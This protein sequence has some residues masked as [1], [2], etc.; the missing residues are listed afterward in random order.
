MKSRWL[1]R[2]DQLLLAAALLATLAF[3]IWLSAP[4]SGAV[5][6]A[7]PS[8]T[9]VRPATSVL[10]ESTT[11][12]PPSTTPVP[13][14]HTK[15]PHTTQNWTPSPTTPEHSHSTTLPTSFEERTT[16]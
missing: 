10:P 7:T 6:P 16:P 2:S 14:P 13:P 8:T 9:P 15:P 12:T 1:A 5:A 11:T 3:G 4:Q